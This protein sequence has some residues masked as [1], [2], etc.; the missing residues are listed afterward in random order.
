M[1]DDVLRQRKISLIAEGYDAYCLF[2]LSGIENKISDELN[3]DYDCLIATPL[4]RMAHRSKN[5]VKYDVEEIMLKSYIFLFVKKDINIS[6]IKS[7]F[8]FFKVLSKNSDSG[9]LYGSDLKYANWVLDN[10]G[11]ISVSEAIKQDGKVKIVN[12]P[13][14]DL[15]GQIIEYSKKNRNCCIEIDLLGQTIKTWLPFDW[16][17]SK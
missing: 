2:T 14:K 12:G 9:K 8:N 11:L 17:D 3:K 15:E 5:G 16:I 1:F 6:T 10:D 13:L 7:K 4:S